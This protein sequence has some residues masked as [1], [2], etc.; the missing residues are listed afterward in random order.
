MRKLIMST[1]AA[2]SVAGGMAGTAMADRCQDVHI[3]VDNEFE[4][5]G[6]FLQIKIV[7]FDYWDD[8]EGKWREENFVGNTIA[9]PHENKHLTERN[10]EYVGGQSGTVIRVQFQY[11][12]A[13][14]GWSESL[15][16]ES[17]EFTCTD[18]RLV[19]VRVD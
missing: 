14:N 4:E 7:D 2:L 13:E 9:Q 10:L 6:D 17:S 8:D 19:T 12:T 16:A 15:N 1:I 18:G 11:L 3:H 5:D